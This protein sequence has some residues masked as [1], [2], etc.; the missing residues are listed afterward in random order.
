MV[1]RG[2]AEGRCM[3][4]LLIENLGKGSGQQPGSTGEHKSA[5]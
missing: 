2:R 1:R 4:E 3:P 5:E